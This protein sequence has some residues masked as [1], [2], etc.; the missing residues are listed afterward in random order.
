M[1]SRRS[2]PQNYEYGFETWSIGPRFNAQ[3]ISDWLNKKAQEG[4]GLWEII[5]KHERISILMRKY[6]EPKKKRAKKKSS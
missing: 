2:N 5:Q 6:N 3:K 1:R 4:F